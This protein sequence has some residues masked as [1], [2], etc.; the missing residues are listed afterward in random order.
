[1]ENKCET[2]DTLGQRILSSALHE[3]AYHELVLGGVGLVKC[4]RPGCPF[5][6]EAGAVIKRFLRSD[7]HGGQS[8]IQIRAA[9]CFLFGHSFAKEYG[10]ATDE[11]IARTCT[12]HGVNRER[13]NVFAAVAACEQGAV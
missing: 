12:I 3:S 13:A 8:R 1:M 9:N 11:G 4:S 5:G 10:E 6:V 2:P 7:P